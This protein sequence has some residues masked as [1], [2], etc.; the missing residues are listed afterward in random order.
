M[1]DT[2]ATAAAAACGGEAGWTAS[3]GVSGLGCISWRRGCCLLA[4]CICGGSGVAVMESEA[5]AAAGEAGGS[6]AEGAAEPTDG[7]LPDAICC[8]AAGGAETGAAAISL[9]PGSEPVDPLR[10]PAPGVG[11][12][13]VVAGDE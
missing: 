8:W 4:V 2:S 5:N 7:F 10:L 13:T 1:S 11:G 3:T 12:E 6:G 9:W